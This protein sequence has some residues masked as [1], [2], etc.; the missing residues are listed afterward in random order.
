MTPSFL[1]ST[2]NASSVKFF[3]IR[4]HE[5][6]LILRGSQDEAS[7]VLLHGTLVLCLSEPLKVQNIHM[8]FTGESRIGFPLIAG[9]R[10]GN[11]YFKQER[12]F[13]RENWNFVN[14]GKG[15]SE[16]LPAGNYEYPFEAIVP[17]NMPESIEGLPDSW[18]VYRMKATID[19]GIWASNVYARKHIRIIRTFDP[20]ALELAHAM[21]V[22]NVWPNKV[23][24][25]LSTP[26]KGVIFGTDIQVNFS[27][28]PLLK[29]LRIGSVI[30][31]LIE[32]QDMTPEHPSHAKNPYRAARIVHSDTYQLPEGT[33]AEDIGGQEGYVFTRLI[34]IPKSLR[35][36]VQSVEER[37]IKIRHRLKFVIQLINPDSHISEASF[38]LVISWGHFRS[39]LFLQLRATLPVHIFISPNLLMNENNDLIEQSLLAGSS[40]DDVSSCA[41][42]LYGEHR[43]DQLYSEVDPSGYLTPAG[44]SSGVNTPFSTSRTAS[45][46]NLFNM[47]PVAGAI[48]SGVSANNLQTRLSNIQ[49]PGSSRWA[50]DRLHPVGGVLGLHEGISED[51][52]LSAREILARNGHYMS[53]NGTPR[54]PNSNPLSRRNS[55]EEGQRTSSEPQTPHHIENEN[56]LEMQI[57]ILSK[58]PSY[59][60]ALQMPVRSSFSDDLPTYQ[61]AVSRPT[62]P[63]SSPPHVTMLPPIASRSSS[64][65]SVSVTT[66]ASREH[67]QN[68]RHA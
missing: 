27:L 68:Q 25:S 17:G 33:E 29:G 39:N 64:T 16:T 43:F 1:T 47:S 28:I 67:V 61:I 13:H 34:P 45:S 18:I 5:N 2:G 14:P 35:R 44:A 46:E 37:G 65:S 6:N 26:S 15:H 40:L 51:E 59:Q 21:S 22:D 8:R 53:C 63:S 49:N 23:E 3:E 4:V 42:P 56:P 62:T 38:Q 32:A 50:R 52:H 11:G 41:P 19:R 36:C 48:A 55:N 30:T 7:S 9:S 66:M 24:Y 20:G 54:Q 31:E 12:E 57:N 10:T 58:V 60:T